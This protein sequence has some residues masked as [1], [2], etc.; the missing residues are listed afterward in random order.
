MRVRKGAM[1]VMQ[2]QR[3]VNLYRLIDTMVEGKVDVATPSEDK[4]DDTKL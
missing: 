1:V 2:V 3:V 4:E